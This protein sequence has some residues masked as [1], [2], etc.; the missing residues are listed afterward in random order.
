M[1][2]NNPGCF[3]YV[4][5]SGLIAV[6]VVLLLIFPG[7]REPVREWVEQHGGKSETAQS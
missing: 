1:N 5:V 6:S 2:N 3:E 7:L 4:V